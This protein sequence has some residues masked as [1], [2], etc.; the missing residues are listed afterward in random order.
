[1]QMRRIEGC[2]LRWLGLGSV[3]SRE[4]AAYADPLCRYRLG[5]PQHRKLSARLGHVH[6]ST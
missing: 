6:Y 2:D 3:A 4:C 1:M 5:L